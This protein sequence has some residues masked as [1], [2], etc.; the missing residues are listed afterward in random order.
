[1]SGRKPA[2]ERFAETFAMAFLM[3]ATSV[4]RRFNQIVNESGD[5]RIADL[6]R[7]SHF[8]FVSV[9]AMTIRLENLGVIPK[10]VR[11][12]LKESRFKVRQAVQVLD[13]RQHPVK[14]DPFP[15]RYVFL[16]VH[17]FERGELSEGEL[18]AML[19]CDRVTTREIVARYLTT[20]QLSDNGE[21]LQTQLEPQLSL[22]SAAKQ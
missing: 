8:Y 10:G 11:E 20:T 16:A 21:I 1:M 18:A 12:Y 14:D 6:C 22:L 17:A 7:L 13:L 3:P 4:R 2:N 15:D 9:E 5:F 19:R